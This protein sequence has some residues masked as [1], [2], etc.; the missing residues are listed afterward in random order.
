MAIAL[1]PLGQKVIVRLDEVKEVKIGDGSLYA[2]DMHHESTRFATVVSVGSLVK[3]FKPGDRVFLGYH[4]GSVIEK[5][6]MRQYGDT[7]RIVGE[8]EIWGFVRE[9]SDGDLGLRPTESG[10][11]T[12]SRTAD[13]FRVRY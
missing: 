6:E 11:Q 5:T 7:L 9:D 4:V 13:G 2:P 10:T 3:E 1:E 8:G 12:T